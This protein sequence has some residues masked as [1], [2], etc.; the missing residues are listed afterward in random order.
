MMDE[1]VLEHITA[2]NDIRADLFLPFAI[3]RLRQA[4]TT[5]QEAILSVQ[6]RDMGEVGE[7]HKEL[8][9]SWSASSMGEEKIP[10]Q[11]RVVT[12]WAAVGIACVLVPLY[13]E[14]CVLQ[15]TQAGDGFDYW[16]GDDEWEYALE[17]SGTVEGGLAG[18]H[19]A[20]VR[21][22]QRNPHGVDGY[23]AVTRFASLESIF[24]FNRYKEIT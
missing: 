19:A 1:Y 24:S 14:L 7:S 4:I 6:L 11:E 8:L 20:K 3:I 16:V 17:V 15:V 13:A 18:R 5:D 10:L 12:E 21:Q 23:V 22:L 2:D 9:L